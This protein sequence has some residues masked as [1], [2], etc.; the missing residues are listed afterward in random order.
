MKTTISCKPLFRFFNVILLFCL[1]ISCKSN[2]EK[3]TANLL[4]DENTSGNSKGAFDFLPTSTTKVI[5]K[6]E[7][8]TLTHESTIL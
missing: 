2:S 7:Q 6:H 3:D 1:I 5:V 4:L 8:F